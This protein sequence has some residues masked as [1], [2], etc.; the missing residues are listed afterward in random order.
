MCLCVQI[1]HRLEV[2]PQLINSRCFPVFKNAALLQ[3]VQPPSGR[4][5]EIHQPISDHF[6]CI[7]TETLLN[8]QDA[9]ILQ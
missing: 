2:F 1:Q 7:D 6:P 5:L 9:A 4:L 3:P 8:Y